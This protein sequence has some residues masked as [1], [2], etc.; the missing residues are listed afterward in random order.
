ELDLKNQQARDNVDVWRRQQALL[1]TEVEHVGK[2]AEKIGI[3]SFEL[4]LKRNELEQAEA[5][6]KKLREEKER[7]Q[8]EVQSSKQ[9]VSVLHPA[10]V[11]NRKNVAAQ[12]RVVGFA[13]FAGLLL[14]LFGVAWWEARARRV[15]GEHEV[16]NEVG[17]RV[18]G[19][20][21]RLTGEVR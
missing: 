8:V 3:T 4:E 19:V 18:V 1:E 17:L 10:E 2:E 12:A 9:R 16:V 14:G 15:I 5:V 6:I 13:G 7:L 11:P 20:L 21:P